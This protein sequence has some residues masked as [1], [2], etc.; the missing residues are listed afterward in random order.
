VLA[1]SHA[2][3][4]PNLA[5]RATTFG[6]KKSKQVST[7]PSKHTAAAVLATVEVV[8]GAD[9]PADLQLTASLSQSHA[10][11]ALHT[12]RCRPLHASVLPEGAASVVCASSVH[13]LVEPF[14][15]HE[16]DATLHALRALL[17]HPSSASVALPS[18][19]ASL[20]SLPSLAS[21]SADLQL[22]EPP[23]HVHAALALHTFAFNPLHES[24]TSFASVPTAEQ[25][26]VDESH[27][28]TAVARHC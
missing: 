27:K 11:L 1:S 10:A 26:C 12:F 23:S 5:L 6:L 9:P 14:Q 13:C 4:D 20:P 17:L 8:V 19:F 2:T 7:V 21:A 24:L 22:N 18:S 16:S 25:D 28:Q 3:W 15:A